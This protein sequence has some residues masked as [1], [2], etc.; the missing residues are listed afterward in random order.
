VYKRQLL[1][2]VV[3]PLAAAASGALRVRGAPSEA[4]RGGGKG[5]LGGRA[6]R[7]ALPALAMALSTVSLVAALSFGAALWKM[8]QIDVGYR[9]DGVHAMQLFRT[10]AL[11]S[12]EAFATQVQDRLSALPGVDAVAVTSIAPLSNIGQATMELQVAG[13][14]ESEPMLV[15]FR[16]VSPGFRALLHIPLLSGRDFSAADRSGAEAVAIINRTAARRIFGDA[17]PLGQQVSLPLQRDQ[18]VP[19]RIVGVMDDI[20]NDGLRAPAQPEVM[21]PFAQ[22]PSVAMTFLSRSTAALSGIDGQMADA[23]WA[24]DPHQSITRQFQLADDLAQETRATRFFARTVGA[25]A[26]AALL[27]AVLGVYAVASLQQQ[28][29]VAEF[30]LRLA[31]GAPPRRLALTV[32]R[33]SLRA[34][35]TGIGLGLGGAYLLLRV[36][37]AQLFNLAGTDQTF[38]LMAGVC[39]MAAAA[40]LAALLPALRAT[41]I[42]PI[43]A[44]RAN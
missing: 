19:C 27:L 8:Q 16:R 17:Q 21:V 5:L 15:S 38:L 35:I 3:A 33:D 18:R 44:L 1:L 26:L 4:I 6:P 23:L 9:A 40:L 2:G 42:D 20:R 29:R 10:G 37:Q 34:S 39:A 43:T 7:R 32:L 28:S 14:A 24:V 12:A 41:R 22:F 30:G 36:L 13:R 25:F 31:I 11:S